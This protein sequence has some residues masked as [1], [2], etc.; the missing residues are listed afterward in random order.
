MLDKI[1]KIDLEAGLGGRYRVMFLKMCLSK[2]RAGI[3]SSMLA[4]LSKKNSN[5]HELVIKAEEEADVFEKAIQKLTGK[6]DMPNDEVLHQIGIFGNDA[7]AYV[8]SLNK[9]F[10][11]FKEIQ[12]HHFDHIIVLQ[13]A[14]SKNPFREEQIRKVRRGGE[15]LQQDMQQLSTTG[16]STSSLMKIATEKGLGVG[17]IVHNK[18]AMH[19]IQSFDE[20]GGVVTLS[21]KGDK[22]RKSTVFLQDLVDNFKPD[23]TCNKSM[24]N[25]SNRSKAP[26]CITRANRWFRTLRSIVHW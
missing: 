12:A 13:K 21:L 15:P 24:V 6:N 2:G 18:T 4:A 20:D 14:K 10:K 1:N 23:D 22:R 7:V 26:I 17:A 3:S 8:H 16:L 9:R 5:Q 11:S 25:R 19:T